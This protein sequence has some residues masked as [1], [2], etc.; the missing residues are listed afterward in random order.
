MRHEHGRHPQ[1][2][3]QRLDLSPEKVE[4]HGRTAIERGRPAS[5]CERGELD[6]QAE[7]VRGLLLAQLQDVAEKASPTL[8]V[9]NVDEVGE[10]LEV[11]SLTLPPRA[12]R[13]Q[14]V[15]DGERGAAQSSKGL[16]MADLGSVRSGLWSSVSS[17][18]GAGSRRF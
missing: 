16:G 5:L 4:G 1:L 10:Y 6:R 12:A 15:D 14:K 2:R 11:E 17:A 7:H 13:V 9:R 3:R 18:S 8:A